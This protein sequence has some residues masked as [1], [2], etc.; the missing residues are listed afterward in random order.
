VD[1]WLAVLY[2]VSR[3]ESAE[4]S[5]TF[6]DALVCAGHKPIAEIEFSYDE[7]NFGYP[8]DPTGICLGDSGSPLYDWTTNRILGFVS[9]TL[10]TS[11]VGPCGYGLDIYTKLSQEIVDWVK[12]EVYKKGMTVVE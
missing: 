12:S 1:A 3:G 4:C 6:S 8:V 5:F 9:D 2:Y 7:S 11:P 10:S